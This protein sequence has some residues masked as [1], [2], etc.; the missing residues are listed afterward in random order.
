MKSIPFVL[1]LLFLGAC[2]AKG[3]TGFVTPDAGALPVADGYEGARPAVSV[4]DAAERKVV[5]YS[6][7]TK[8]P[9]R[10][11][12]CSRTY[13]KPPGT[14]MALEELLGWSVFYLCSQATDGNVPGSYI[15]KRRTEIEAV[16]DELIAAGVRPSNIFLAGH[17]AGAWS[18]LMAMDVA[19]AKFNAGILFAPACCGPR[20]EVNRYPHWRKEIRPRQVARI[21]AKPVRALVF[22]FPEDAFNRPQ[23]LKFLIDAFPE[24]VR[25]I[26]PECGRRHSDHAA[27]CGKDAKVAAAIR[28]Y[29][30]ER[31]A[32]EPAS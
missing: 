25:M 29:V 21:V 32:A 23:E 6:H 5:V 14:I 15:G 20:H 3:P 18:S 10:R 9:Q 13:N 31:L 8:R 4:A 11:E 30:T 22:A 24:T 12:D 19:G 1:T 26:V 16:L 27:R 2:V 17:S 7:G 28:A